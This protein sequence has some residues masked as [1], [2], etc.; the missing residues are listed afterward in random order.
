[1]GVELLGQQR[2]LLQRKSQR[3]AQV[4]HYALEPVGADRARE[5][6]ELGAEVAVHPLYQ[7]VPQPP[8]EVQVYVRQRSHVVGYEALQ[9]EVP[10]QRVHMADAYEVSHQQRDG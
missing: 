1:M 5:H 2:N 10:P 9:R 6:G 8:G 3:L 4:S 7:L